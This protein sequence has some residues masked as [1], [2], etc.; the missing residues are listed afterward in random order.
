MTDS[1]RDGQ[2]CQPRPAEGSAPARRRG[3]PLVRVSR[4]SDFSDRE[5][6]L[7]RIW[8]DRLILL[9]PEKIEPGDVL[10]IALAGAFHQPGTVIVGQVDRVALREDEAWLVSVVL[11]RHLSWDVVV[12]STTLFAV[13]CELGARYRPPFL[14][15]PRDQT[16]Q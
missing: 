1:Q 2:P 7:F 6:V 3:S 12:N 14:L 4:G 11:R 13:L 9:I 15:A 5:A 10:S 16:G 8:R